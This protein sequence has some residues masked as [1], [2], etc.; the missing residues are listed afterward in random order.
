MQ[1]YHPAL[2]TTHTTFSLH[3]TANHFASL[4]SIPTQIASLA[5]VQLA[6]AAAAPAALVAAV[7]QQ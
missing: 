6:A 3:A 7:S 5:L 2:P 1:Q 4:A